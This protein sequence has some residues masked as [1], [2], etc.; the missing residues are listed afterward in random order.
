MGLFLTLTYDL[1]T[2]CLRCIM[3]HAFL[4]YTTV[5]TVQLYGATEG[6]LVLTDLLLNRN[7]IDIGFE[8]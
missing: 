5:T 8:L 4:L 6:P 3:E 1:V 7:A 2:L